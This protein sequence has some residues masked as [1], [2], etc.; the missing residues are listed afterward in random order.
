MRIRVT[1]GAH[2]FWVVRTVAAGTAGCFVANG[3][4]MGNLVCLGAEKDADDMPDDRA[5]AL[6]IAIKRAAE[7][8]CVIDLVRDKAIW[9]EQ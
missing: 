2:V 8:P 1:Q 4:G 9:E 7:Q 3:V 6:S 5:I